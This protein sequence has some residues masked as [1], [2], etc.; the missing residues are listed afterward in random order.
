MLKEGDPVYLLD[1]RGKRY[2]LRIQNGMVKV[3]GLGVVDCGKLIGQPD[4]SSVK[5]AGQE[6]FVFLGGIVEQMDS[7]DRG[8][9]IITPKDAATIVLRLDLKAGDAFWKRGRARAR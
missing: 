4:G 1:D 7:L 3:Q 6:F 8:P 2:W 5:L 9:Q